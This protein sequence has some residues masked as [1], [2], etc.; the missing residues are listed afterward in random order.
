MLSLGIVSEDDR[1]LELLKLEYEKAADRYQE[2]YRSMWTI[3]SYLSAVSAGV[4]AVGFDKVNTSALFAIASIPLIFW[5]TTTYLPLDRYGNKVLDRLSRMELQAE[6]QFHFAM[7]HFREVSEIK[8]TDTIYRVIR[9]ALRD[10]EH[11]DKRWKIICSQVC[12]ARFMI[13]IWFLIVF[14][15]SLYSAYA[16]LTSGQPFLLRQEQSPR[17]MNIE[18]IQSAPFVEIAR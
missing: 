7:N 1:K 2:I 4:L 18:F 15:G 13:G 5:F 14:L 3:F 11:K 16:F 12:R 8:T 9:R 10:K 17:P 6:T